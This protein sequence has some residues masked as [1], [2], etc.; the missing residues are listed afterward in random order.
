MWMYFFPERSQVNVHCMERNKQMSYTLSL[1]GAGLLHNICNCHVSSTVIQTLP[2]LSGSL[3]RKL[4]TP[5]FYLPENHSAI[6]DYEAQ[7]IDEMLPDSVKELDK[8]ASR[9]QIQKQT[10]DVSLLLHVH[11]GTMQREKQT[12]WYIILSTSVSAI[13]ILGIFCFLLYTHFHKLKCCSLPTSSNPDTATQ[14]SS[15]QTQCTQQDT[16][17]ASNAEAE[18]EVV[19]TVYCLCT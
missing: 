5:N 8:V 10:L 6:T 17:V 4:D 14:T 15:S 13:I 18:R 9:I 11:Q 12:Y 2:K 1:F 7:Q 19:F 3:Q 16:N